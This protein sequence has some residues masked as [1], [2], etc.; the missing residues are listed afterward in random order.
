MKKYTL[1]LI[2]YALSVTLSF[3]HASKSVGTISPT[4]YSS[5][6]L[7]S[8]EGVFQVST[9]SNTTK[10][11]WN[12]PAPHD[13][14]VTD[15]GLTGFLW[16]PLT[17]FISLNCLNTSSCAQSDFKVSVSPIGAL[18]GYAWGENTGW[19]S[20]NC[21]NAETNNCSSNGNARVTI[22]DSG[23]FLGHAW[24]ENFGWIAFSCS[25][26]STCVKTDWRR[27]GI[28]GESTSII[29]P[30][31]KAGGGTTNILYKGPLPL[32][33]EKACHGASCLTLP[34]N[35]FFPVQD[36]PKAVDSNLP[37][38]SSSKEDALT[39]DAKESV[40]AS[41]K[42]LYKQEV[43]SLETLYSLGDVSVTILSPEKQVVFSIYINGFAFSENG[44]LTPHIQKKVVD[45]QPSLRD[46]KQIKRNV[47]YE[48]KA[49]GSDGK[50]RSTFKEGLVI[51]LPVPNQFKDASLL[52]LY[53][54]SK[55]K[56]TWRLIKKVAYSDKVTFTVKHLSF[57]KIEELESKKDIMGKG[58]FIVILSS[59][60][61][62][63][64]ILLYTIRIR[65]TY[66]RR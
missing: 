24:S 54:K 44:L 40:F 12:I 55:E 15:D 35:S 45:L 57:F 25:S 32:Q 52:G 38:T 13:V 51:T 59:L 36:I 23:E 26:Y 49:I 29:P 21:S 42:N 20:F 43:V 16:G 64:L 28:R 65:K 39:N 63:V 22:N 3:V 37:E 61:L 60:S 5:E 34:I 17:G 48:I 33:Q 27:P 10:I 53:T 46:A 18:S 6:F 58:F 66:G 31:S 11:F 30:S 50:N 41:A 9:S 19:I 47:I 62:I 1:S 8:F 7:S 4:S 56:D 2:L 14:K